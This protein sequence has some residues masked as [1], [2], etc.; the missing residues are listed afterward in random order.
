MI[1]FYSNT[2]NIFLVA[3]NLNDIQN[4]ISRHFTQKSIDFY[5]SGNENLLIRWQKFDDIKYQIYKFKKSINSKNTI[6]ININEVT[7][8][9][10]VK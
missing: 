3:K 4:A 6:K 5:P 8:K 7:T 10:G 1:S 2:K 9:F